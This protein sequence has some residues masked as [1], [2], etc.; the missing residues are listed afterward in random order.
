MPRQSAAEWV[1]NYSMARDNKPSAVLNPRTGGRALAMCLSVLIATLAQAQNSQQAPVESGGSSPIANGGAAGATKGASGMDASASLQS[2]GLKGA[3][4][5]A[6]AEPQVQSGGPAVYDSAAAREGN[7]SISAPTVKNA[8]ESPSRPEFIAEPLEKHGVVSAAPAGRAPGASG[9]LSGAGR[10]IQRSQ[11]EELRGSDLS[12][13]SS[14][15]AIFDAARQKPGKGPAGPSAAVAGKTLQVEAKIKQTI[16]VANGAASADAPSLYQSAISIAKDVFSPDVSGAVAEAVLRS[17]DKKA[18]T[19]LP[20]LA[21]QAYAAAAAGSS[22]AVGKTF[23]AFSSWD[24]LLGA[25]DRPLIENYSHLKS[26]IERAL[27]NSAVAASAASGTAANVWFKRVGAAKFTA[28]LPGSAVAAIPQSLVSAFAIKEEGAQVQDEDGLWRSF[29][30][31][32]SP[33]YIYAASRRAGGSVSAGIWGE[34]KYWLRTLLESLWGMTRRLLAKI[35]GTS[36]SA[37]WGAGQAVETRIGGK[38]FD[39][40]AVTRGPADAATKEPLLKL[41]GLSAQIAEVDRLMLSGVRDLRGARLALAQAGKAASQFQA[42]TGDASPGQV[43]AS[44]AAS[45]DKDAARLGLSPMDALPD[46][47]SRFIGS[48]QGLSLAYWLDRMREEALWAAAPQAEGYAALTGTERGGVAVVRYRADRASDRARAEAL[49]NLGFSV[50]YREGVAQAAL[51]GRTASLSAEEMS[52]R[53]TQG[54]GIARGGSFPRKVSPDPSASSS[55]LGRLLADVKNKASAAEKTAALLQSQDP[56]PQRYETIG[57]VGAMLA[58]K[59][60][61][62][63]RSGRSV[64]VIVLRDQEQGLIAFARVESLDGKLESAQDIAP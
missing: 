44:L 45:V 46:H 61:R 57:R 33:S 12:V 4:P 34:S 43:I 5:G 56:S 16:N 32:P 11:A 55:E 13:Q 47:L 6:S 21:A 10:Q 19:A 49:E 36:A 27:K 23:K 63:N 51:T 24:R 18:E 1:Y 37:N 50:S 31:H 20:D 64:N 38:Y 9:A 41:A 48:S 3:L 39:V 52:E 53:L 26:D 54:V 22:A 2:E 58:Q 59:V 42:L 40:K 62:R 29:L 25:Q 17:A 28:V 15:E 14:L 60:Q 7:G 8:P 30:T 35:L